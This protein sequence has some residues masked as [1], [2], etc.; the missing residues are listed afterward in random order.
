M[1]PAPI[2]LPPPSSHAC[3]LQGPAY[4]Q[5]TEGEKLKP[6]LQMGLYDMLVHTEVDSWHITAQL[7][8][9]SCEDSG[10][11]KASQWAEIQAGYLIV[12][13]VWAERWPEYRS[14]LIHGQLLMVWLDSQGLERK[15]WKIGDMEILG[16]GTCLDPSE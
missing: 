5:L 11:G 2:A 7:G 9:G 8:G 13:C 10:E 6:G 14:T 12:H 3:G 16:R 1:G 15:D 4:D